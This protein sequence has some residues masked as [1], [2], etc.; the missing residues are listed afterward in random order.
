[1][2]HSRNGTTHVPSFPQ[3][4]NA[5][6]VQ[7]LVCAIVAKAEVSLRFPEL[8]A[9]D[10]S[11]RKPSLPAQYVGAVNETVLDK[12]VLC[13]EDRRKTL[14]S[15]RYDRLSFTQLIQPCISPAQQYESFGLL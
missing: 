14:R 10:H 3:R 6:F 8:L 5:Y 13:T 2:V 4:A 11:I 7:V 15:L 1:L 12:I 9:Q